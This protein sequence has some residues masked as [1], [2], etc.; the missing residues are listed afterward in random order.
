MMLRGLRKRLLA[1]GISLFVV[2]ISGNQAYSREKREQAPQDTGQ[3]S[4]QQISDFSLAGFNEQGK[5]SWDLAGKTAD[6][7]DTVVKLQ[8]VKGNLFSE[9]E[10]IKLTAE[11]GDFDKKEGKVH[12]EEDVV[13]TTSSGAKLTTDSLDWDRKNQIVN[14]KD[15]V[16]IKKENLLATAQGATGKPNLNK[17]NLDKDVQVEILPVKQQDEQGEKAANKTIITCDGPLEIDYE[18][19]I[20]TFK[21]DVKVDNKDILMYSDIMD[22]YFTKEEKQAGAAAGQG[23]AAAETEKIVPG[24]NSKISRIFARGNVKIIKGEN[25]SYSEEAT[26]VAADKKIILTGRPKLVLSSTEDL[27]VA[28]SGN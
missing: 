8:D 22:V 12:L 25:I 3:D 27:K 20:A 7:F 18:K 4:D 5:K 21:N 28:F 6:I 16:N 19:N 26:Y 15:K 10:E 24:M 11:R 9:N 17:V 14:T 23:K 13:I 1:V 2:L